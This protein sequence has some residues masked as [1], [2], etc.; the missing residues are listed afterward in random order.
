MPATLNAVTARDSKCGYRTRG[1]D[2]MTPSELLEWS[3]LDLLDC[4]AEQLKHAHS[5]TDRRAAL[6]VARGC[7][8]P[9]ILKVKQEP[10]IDARLA[11]AFPFN[12]YVRSAFRDDLWKE[13]DTLSEA[14]FSNK[15]KELIDN[16]QDLKD[17]IS[18]R[19]R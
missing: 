19:S 4:I 13:L 15:T 6:V 8:E 7:V 16:I 17:A 5:S 2:A 14:D 12:D 18:Q 9:L 10:Q 11:F 3:V 1:R